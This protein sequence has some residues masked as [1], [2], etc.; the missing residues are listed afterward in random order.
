MS[1]IKTAAQRRA[2][3]MDAINK[4]KKDKNAVMPYLKFKDVVTGTIE[5]VKVLKAKTGKTGVE[6][7][8]VE[9]E[10]TE[11]LRTVQG[12]GYPNRRFS[13]RRFWLSPKTVGKDFFFSPVRFAIAVGEATGNDKIETALDNPKYLLENDVEALIDGLKLMEGSQFCTVIGGEEKFNKKGE[14]VVYGILNLVEPA[15]SCTSENLAYLSD[16]AEFASY[17]ILNKTKEQAPP[18]NNPAPEVSLP[19]NDDLPF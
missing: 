8:F 3:L 1:E 16:L 13:T 7:V 4:G 18:V 11:N 14:K 9:D 5:E 15:M 17:R 6:V 12:Y 10:E 2:E 19:N